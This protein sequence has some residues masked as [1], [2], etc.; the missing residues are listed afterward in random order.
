[1]LPAHTFDD[2]SRTHPYHTKSFPKSWMDCLG[3]CL[4]S[5]SRLTRGCSPK[6]GKVMIRNLR[7]FLEHLFNFVF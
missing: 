6:K 2:D 5:K 1:M 3:E 7:K 4:R